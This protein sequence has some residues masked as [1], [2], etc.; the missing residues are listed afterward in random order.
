[1]DW[2]RLDWT[3]LD[4]T[5]V[6]PT[7]SLKSPIHMG[8]RA[9]LTST[10]SE[11]CSWMWATLSRSMS[12]ALQPAR[13]SNQDMFP[14]STC[15]V[16]LESW[17]GSDGVWGLSGWSGERERESEMETKRARERSRGEREGMERSGREREG[18][19]EGGERETKTQNYCRLTTE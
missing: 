8:V 16:W 1:V 14:S 19:R 11:A 9:R 6:V 4:W 3:R 17:S 5:A 7:S 18:E 10:V 12:W 15:T 2:T 13:A